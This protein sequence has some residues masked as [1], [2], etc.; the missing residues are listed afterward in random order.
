MCAVLLRGA[1]ICLFFCAFIDFW[2]RQILIRTAARVWFRFRLQRFVCATARLERSSW[3]RYLSSH[4]WTE[5]HGVMISS[6]TKRWLIARSWHEHSDADAPAII[7][8]KSRKCIRSTLLPSDA[9]GRTACAVSARRSLSV[10]R[11]HPPLWWCE[12]M[13]FVFLLLFFCFTSVKS[14]DQRIIPHT[15][16]ET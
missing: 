8:G 14:L 12:L 11:S 5:V 15:I 6:S 13:I 10:R 9:V 4:K 1:R 16:N 2:R 7:T 3:T